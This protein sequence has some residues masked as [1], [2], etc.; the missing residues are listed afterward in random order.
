[1]KELMKGWSIT[2]ALVLGLTAVTVLFFKLTGSPLDHEDIK[3]VLIVWAIVVIPGKW[4][5]TRLRRKENKNGPA[6]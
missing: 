3:F 6:S 4:I 1:M 2:T 5:W